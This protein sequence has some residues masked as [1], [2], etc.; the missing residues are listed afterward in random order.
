MIRKPMLKMNELIMIDEPQLL[1]GYGQKMEDPRDGLTLFGPIENDIP[2]GIMSGVVGTTEGLRKFKNY[3]GSLRGP[4]LNANNL[5]RPFFPGFE[6]VFKA[7]WDVDKINFAEIT[8]SEIGKELYHADTHTRTFKL[9]SL[10]ADKI[11]RAVEDEDSRPDVWFVIIP[12]LIYT[13]CRPNATVPKQLVTTE[14][15]T[16]KT[17]A[18]KMIRSGAISLFD[19]VNQDIEPYKYD[20]HFHNQL[21]ARLLHK[22]IPTQI[23]RESTLDWRNIR[24][25]N[26]AYLRDFSKIEGHLAWC[27]ATAAFYKTGGRPWKLADIRPGVC[28]VGLVYKKDDRSGDNRNACCAAQM[29]LDSGDGIV[30]KGA[31]GPWY[32]DTTEEYHLRREQAK[33]LIGVAVRTYKNMRGEY[34]NE[35]FIHARTR[36]DRNEW[37]GFRDAVPDGTNVV[38]ITINKRKPLKI[39]RSDSDFPM[40]RG[41]AYI[42][43]T[44]SGFLWTKGYVPRL[45]TSLAM[46][47]PN[48]LY[49]EIDKGVADMETVLI[50]IL[51]LTKLNYNTCIYGDGLPVTLRFADAIGEILTAAPLDGNSPPL[52]FKYYI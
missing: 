49:I 22:A 29:F 23:V 31:V 33:E 7:K 47:V 32:N 25:S 45:E 6:T 34:P 52:S 38:C 2:Y 51:A 27:I 40:L 24:K 26:G 37:E 9:V 18:Q 30:F 35:L 17:T 42:Q 10:F 11:I 4:I 16:K 50:D 19:F 8:D 39:F 36:F 28:Y 43:S 41:L 13:Y 21:K 3:L 46:E 44:M 20:A 48:P 12:D 5:S 1:F 14:R 15:R